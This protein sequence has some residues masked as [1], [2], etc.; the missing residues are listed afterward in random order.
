MKLFEINDTL[1]EKNIWIPDKRGDLDVEMQLL[2]T[3]QGAP[4][5]IEGSLY[6]SQNHLTSF[7]YAPQYIGG[8]IWCYY[9]QFKS[10]KDIHKHIKYIG[11][12]INIYENP[13]ESHILGLCLIK[14]LKKVKIDSKTVGSVEGPLDRIFTLYL[15]DINLC[16]EA[17]ID[18]GYPELARL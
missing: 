9:N 3:F 5:R 15:H 18:A 16:Q 11:G 14:G 13:I 12:E 4:T 17:L 6:C 7:R 1:T 8:D 10:L 2:T